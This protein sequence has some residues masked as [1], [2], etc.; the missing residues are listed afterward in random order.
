VTSDQRHAL[1]RIA[2]EAVNNAVRHG[3][4]RRISVR[5]TTSQDARCLLIRDDGSGFE[6][7]TVADPGKSGG[8]GYGLISMRDR[9]RGLPGSLT[10]RSTP[11]TG[12][13]VAVQW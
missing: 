13:E 10:I 12:S 6:V 5:L 1:V 7:E 2:R 4:A 8:T 11:G 3:R 9:A